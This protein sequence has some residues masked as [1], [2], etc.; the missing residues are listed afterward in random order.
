MKAT[1]E[2]RVL[3]LETA[4]K[5]IWPCS[6][7]AV[8]VDTICREAGVFKGSF[9]HFFPSKS[10]LMAA[11][12]EHHWLT[13]QPHFDRIFAP[14]TPPVQRILRY[15][16]HAR[17]R[18]IERKQET[19]KVLG[20]PYASIGAEVSLQDEVIAN[21]IR[22]LIDRY[23]RYFERAL[24][25]ANS[26]G[27]LKTENPHA[28]AQELFAYLEGTLT[29]ARMRNDIKLLSGLPIGAMAILGIGGKAA[30]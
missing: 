16:E 29:L 12:L 9:Y 26:S 11:A 13:N 27:E 25:D 6:Y 1:R 7:G 30:A 17:R 21:K 2:T 3:L 22:E 23:T 5:L 8:S 28:K 14:I 20:C 24:E 19:G 4:M 18:Q 15:F 10:E